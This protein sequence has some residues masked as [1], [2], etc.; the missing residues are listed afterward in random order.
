M[1]QEDSQRESL[2]AMLVETLE[3]D[4]GAGSDLTTDYDRDD[5]RLWVQ[6]YQGSLDV[7]HLANDIL[8]W[9]RDS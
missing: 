8:D 3:A 6:G 7:G 5:E 9:V 1:V 4:D 2:I